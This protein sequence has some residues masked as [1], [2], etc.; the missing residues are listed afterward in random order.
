MTKFLTRAG[1][2]AGLFAGAV[3][4]TT[5][6]GQPA[7]VA[8]NKEKEKD[9]DKGPG[10]AEEKDDHSGWWCKPHGIPEEECSMCNDEY[11]KKCKDKGDWCD[12]HDRAA[13]QC[14]I[15][16][17]E[18]KEKFAAKYRAK[19]GTEPPPMKKEKPSGPA[20]AV[21]APAPTAAITIT[22]PDMDCEVCAGK[23]VKKLTAVAGVAKVEA[24]V[25]AQKLTVT[26]KDKETPS[27]KDL[28]EACAAAGYDPAKLEGPGGV[29]TE[30]P[31]Q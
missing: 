21:P 29:F 7:P 15:C 27:P 28:W 25:K 26:P 10:K 23:L 17:P 14:F 20:T 2:L 9:K 6:C 31:K 19:Y 8:E 4:F 3:L 1:L 11:A 24:D 16:N 18:F 12:K 30:K 22:V 5:G 13:S